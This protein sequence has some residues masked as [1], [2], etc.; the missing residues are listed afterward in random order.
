MFINCS[1]IE[2]ILRSGNFKALEYFL[3]ELNKRGIKFRE[4]L[5]VAINN[6]QKSLEDL[7]NKYRFDESEFQ[8]V[9]PAFQ[10]AQSMSHIYIQINMILLDVLRLKMKQL[11]YTRTS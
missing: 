9:S 5:S 4:T 1:C 10:W 6:I 11:I 2:T 3:N 8:K 7:H